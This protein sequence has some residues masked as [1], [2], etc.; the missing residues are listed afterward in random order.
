MLIECWRVEYNRVRPHSYLRC[1]PSAPEAVMATIAAEAPCVALQVPLHRS[2]E[3]VRST[4]S[5]VRQVGA[6]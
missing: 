2:E 4:V 5:L 6:C 3:G 1:R